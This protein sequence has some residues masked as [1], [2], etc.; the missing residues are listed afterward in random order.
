MPELPHRREERRVR[1]VGAS[2]FLFKDVS[3]TLAALRNL[4]GNYGT[5]ANRNVT[6]LR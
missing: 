6:Q 1:D 3:A 5:D 2:E 4:A